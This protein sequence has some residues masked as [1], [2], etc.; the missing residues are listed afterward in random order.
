MSDSNAAAETRLLAQTGIISFAGSATSALM[1]F[2]FT[3]VVAR[4][5]GSYGVGIILQAIAAF[6]ITLGITKL[7]MDSVMVWLLP[8]LR[9]SRSTEIHRVFLFALVIA[10]IG[11]TFGGLILIFL[12]E[13]ESASEQAQALRSLA[14]FVPAGA[15][16]LTALSATRGLGGIKAYVLVGSIFVPTARPILVGIVSIA[17]GTALLATGAWALPLLIGAGAATWIVLRKIRFYGPP[18]GRWPPRSQRRQIVKFAVPRL[19]SVGLEQGLLWLDVVLVGLLAGT[20]AAGVYGGVTR[21][22]AAGLIIDTAVRIVV[23]PRFSMYLHRADQAGAQHLFRVASMWLVLLSTPIY[24]ML[25]IYAPVVLSWLGDEFTP[26]TPTLMLIAAGAAITLMAGNIH[27]MLLMSGHSGWA[28]FNKAVVLL[29]NIVGNIVLVPR[30]G[31]IGAGIAWVSAMLGDALLATIEVRLLVGVR[32]ELGS[33]SYALL[34]PVIAAG[35]PAVII[36]AL[37]GATSLA[38]AVSILVGGALFLGW[39]VLDQNRLH[40]RELRAVSTK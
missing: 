29:I 12:S 23:S 24:L 22:V 27:S 21:L 4:G 34:I 40:L 17:G 15:V 10:G 13:I 35:V 31:I 8:Q 5:F 3:F 36:R 38:L 7:G 2:V 37:L 25:G 18:D 11:G 32:P 6:T 1:G 16:M 39:C 19:I 30:I 9:A 26:G 33:V 20:V 14:W 28:A